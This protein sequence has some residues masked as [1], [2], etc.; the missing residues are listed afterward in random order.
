MT[1]NSESVLIS[2]QEHQEIMGRGQIADFAE[3]YFQSIKGKIKSLPSYI[4]QRTKKDML[5]D[6]YTVL[7]SN[8]SLGMKEAYFRND[9]LPYYT[10]NCITEHG[11]GTIGN[12]YTTEQALQSLKQKKNGKFYFEKDPGKPK[13]TLIHEHIVPKQLFYK[14]LLVFASQKGFDRQFFEFLVDFFLIG[15]TITRTEDQWLNDEGMRDDMP[16]EFYEPEEPS[17]YL[18]P[19]ARYY[20]L[21][22]MGYSDL[23]IRKVN[24]ASDLKSYE[25]V[26]TVDYE[27]SEWLSTWLNYT[28]FQSSCHEWAL[29][30]NPVPAIK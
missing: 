21:Q 13:F 4:E 5:D 3:G 24:W 1:L 8:L 22:Q 29:G 14:P 16:L 10:K 30:M 7:A 26:G 9:F 2:E 27:K 11:R 15:V 18:N 6:A 28:V 19:W 23:I 12:P 25:V 20:K 17:Y